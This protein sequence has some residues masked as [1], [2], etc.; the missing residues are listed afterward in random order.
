M[1]MR[2]SSFGVQAIKRFEGCVL[3]TYKCS[4]GVDTIGYG[5]TGPEV[6]EGLV[7]S[8]ADAEAALVRDLQRFETA[9]EKAINQP[10][11]QGQF[12]ALVSLAFNIGTAAF[13]DSTLVKCFNREDTQAAGLQFIVWNKVKG[14]VDGAL[15]LRRAAEL[16]MFARA[17]V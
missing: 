9:V 4:G 10:M 2:T 14:R 15:L 13:A 1:G 16:W 6:V 5:H 17:S 3:H 12:D 7:W 8:V 11:R